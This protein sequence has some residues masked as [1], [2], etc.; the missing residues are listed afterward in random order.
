MLSKLNLE[1]LSFFKENP[2]YK[3]SFTRGLFFAVGLSYCAYKVFNFIKNGISSL[4]IFEQNLIHK[5][6]DGTWAVITGA[7]DGIGKAFAFQLAQRG[8]SIV[9][10]ARNKDKLDSVQKEIKEKYS[11]IKTRVVVAD[12]VKSA[13]EGFFEKIEAQIQDLDISILVNNVG[14]LFKGHFHETKVSDL[15]DSVVVNCLP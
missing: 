5:Y 7:S 2:L 1:N 8:F 11:N 3:N 4:L 6:G 15:R 10:I 12:F 14:I 9:L 13:D